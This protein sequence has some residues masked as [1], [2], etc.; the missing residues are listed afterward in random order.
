MRISCNGCR[1]LRKGCSDDCTIRPCLQW[2]RNPQSQANATLFLAK[3]Y[4]RAGLVNLIDAGPPHLRPAIFKSL[5]FEACGRIVNPIH[6]SLGLICS[7]SWQLCQAAV[8]AVLKG[9]PIT[10]IS[11][12]S[13]S[14]FQACDIR[15]VSKDYKN[16]SDKL[17]KVKSRSRCKRSGPK[18]NPKKLPEGFLGEFDDSKSH[19]SEMSQHPSNG[20][21]NREGDSVSVETVEAKLVKADGADGSDVELDLTLCL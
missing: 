19:E 7:G 16:S 9:E 12:D 15:H 3:F 18:P 11:S 4:G 10:S 13:E 21:D 20:S 2:I 5:L 17:H 1:V 14:A 8:E 6:G